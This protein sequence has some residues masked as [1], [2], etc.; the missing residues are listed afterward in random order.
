[1]STYTLGWLDR[2]TND[3]RVLKMPFHIRYPVMIRDE[4]FD[5]VG[6]AA[7]IYHL[8]EMIC[9]DTDFVVPGGYVLSMELRDLTVDPHLDEDGLLVISHFGIAGLQ[10]IRA[11]TWAWAG[12]S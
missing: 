11:E 10:L 6:E 1:M 2:R 3:G 4:T 7:F 12:Q 9:C 5:V 8:G